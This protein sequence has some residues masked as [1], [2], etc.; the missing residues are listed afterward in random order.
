MAIEIL[1]KAIKDK[2]QPKENAVTVSH[3]VP[4][5]QALTPR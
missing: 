3:S 2:K 5:V 1:T 4:P